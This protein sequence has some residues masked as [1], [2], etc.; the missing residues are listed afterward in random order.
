M[1][2]KVTPSMRGR[3]KN[4]MHHIYSLLAEP[5]RHWFLISLNRNEKHMFSYS[6]TNAR[7]KI[8]M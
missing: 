3:T 5:E 7:L 4:K 6:Y 1:Q 8:Y 2:I